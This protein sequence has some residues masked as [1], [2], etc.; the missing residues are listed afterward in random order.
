MC[1]FMD[2]DKKQHEGGDEDGESSAALEILKQMRYRKV[3][4][5]VVEVSRKFGQKLGPKRFSYIKNAAK[6]T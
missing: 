3:D 6:G 2:K 5:V 4:N 1:R